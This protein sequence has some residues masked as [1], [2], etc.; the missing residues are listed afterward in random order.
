[1]PWHDIAT[2]VVGSS[3]RDAAR[4]FIQRW[5]AVKLEKARDNLSYPYLM[6][7]TYQEI[8]VDP[9]FISI[10]LH[11]V[12]CQVLRSSSSWSAGFLDPEYVEQSIHEAYIDTITK[13]QHYIYIENQFF[14]SL[15]RGNIY[16]KNG[17]AERLFEKIMR[18]VKE[19]KVFRVFV[20]MPLLPGFEGDVGGTSG[21]AVRAITHWNY[22]SINRGQYSLISRLISAGVEDPFQYIT[23]HSLRT[24]SVLNGTPITELIY[25]H[26][27]LLICDDKTIICGS[28][29][30]NDRSLIGKRDSE[31][32]VIITDESFE[33]GRMNGETFPSGLYAGRLRRFLFR[34]HLGM[35][36]PKPNTY[37]IDI[38]DPISDQFYNGIWRRTSNR[39]TRIFDEVFKCIPTNNTE[40]F[41]QLKNYLEEKPLCQTDVTAAEER[42]KQIEG[43]LV[44]LPLEFL[45][46]EV[47]TPPA[48]SKEGIMPI[49]LWV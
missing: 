11:R 23:F 47:L 42:I 25:V 26:S 30:I 34:E 20:V 6:P 10:P 19:N 36:D 24:H 48:T 33:D 9:N 5:N 22:S 3:A 45:K 46:K 41:V 4:H 37:S 38:N 13:A 21:N 31:V 2:V 1:M 39:N 14:I 15:E 43:Y 28:A 8:K 27:K 40:T 7:R 44:D 29:N 17:I 18:A 32:A 16:V 35:L 12:S 49:S